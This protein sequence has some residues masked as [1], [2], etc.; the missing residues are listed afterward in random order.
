[1]S[2]TEHKCENCSVLLEQGPKISLTFCPLHAAAPRMREEL[3]RISELAD[4]KSS[5]NADNAGNK[6][7]LVAAKS[8][9]RA[10]LREIEGKED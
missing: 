1:M 4:F 3:R 6:M 7:N 8:Y 9:A 5:G 10:L 2:Q